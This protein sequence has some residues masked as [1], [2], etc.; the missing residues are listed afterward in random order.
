TAPT[1][2]ASTRV[3]GRHSPM[4][5]SFAWRRSENDPR[6]LPKYAAPR[7]DELTDECASRAVI[8][9]HRVTEL[10][11]NEEDAVRATG[12]ALRLVEAAE[13]GAD[14]AAFWGAGLAVVALDLAGCRAAKE[15]VPV[16]AEE[17][18]ARIKDVALCS[19]DELADERVVRGVVDKHLA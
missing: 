6:R 15:Q 11:C 14:Y 18:A 13:T 16:G 3:P 4:M 5:G 10:A 12:H 19:G 8:L 9:Q 2:C 1:R 17:Q 7:G